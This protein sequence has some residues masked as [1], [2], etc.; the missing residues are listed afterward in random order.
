MV[1]MFVAVFAGESLIEGRAILRDR[2]P[3]EPALDLSDG[4][5]MG[6][7]DDVRIYNRALSR[8]EVA[9]LARQGGLR[10]LRGR[11]R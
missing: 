10:P 1:L 2:T 4:Y 3:P 7:I 5:F 11:K 8:D 9:A 6:Q